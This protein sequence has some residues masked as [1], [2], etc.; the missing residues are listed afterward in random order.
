MLTRKSCTG[1]EEEP[2]PHADAT[3]SRRRSFMSHVALICDTPEYQ[4]ILPQLLLIN[5]KT[6]SA[7]A[8]AEVKAESRSNFLILDKTSA[9][10]DSDVVV[11]VL[12]LL[13]FIFQ[14]FQDLV[15]L[16]LLLDVCPVHLARRVFAAARFLGICL[17][18]VPAHLTFLL[19]PLDTDVFSHYKL[20]LKRA[21]AD[22]VLQHGTT[23]VPISN[24]VR[25]IISVIES[26]IMD[27][28]WSHSFS[29][30]GYACSRE[31]IGARL[32]KALAWDTAPFIPPMPPNRDQ[33]DALLPTTV[34]FHPDMI[35]IPLSMHRTRSDI[36]DGNLFVEFFNSSVPTIVGE[37]QTS[38]SWV[39][40]ARL[41][42]KTSFS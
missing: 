7:G 20:R 2:D 29:R 38:H 18:L 37:P 39:S 19:Q 31:Y 13:A 3:L 17:V 42:K 26:F 34:P 28:D 16:I 27:K 24:W 4:S 41:R 12:R 30:N 8:V 15:H 22:L 35:Y 32:R 1:A 23:M 21:F 40:K 25:A 6:L 5:K 33:M 9:W 14:P 10:S 36:K 11:E